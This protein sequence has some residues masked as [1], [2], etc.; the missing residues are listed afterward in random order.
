MIL[1]LSAGDTTLLQIFGLVATAVLT[2][3]AGASLTI[4]RLN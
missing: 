3:G 1:N 4:I 2:G